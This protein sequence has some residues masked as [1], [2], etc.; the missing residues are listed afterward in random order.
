VTIP[1]ARGMD[2]PALRNDAEEILR[3][4]ALDMESAQSGEEQVLKSRGHKARTMTKGIVQQKRMAVL[5]FFE[6]FTLNE[7]VSEYRA[8]RAT[9]IRLW[10][11]NPVAREQG[12]STS[13][14]VSRKESTRRSRNRL[15][16]SR[17]G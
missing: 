9:V 8:L 4:I 3:A 12:L 17:I 15:R 5:A 14:S 11:A 2:A 16:A 6:G 1:S 10:L 7:M 13:S